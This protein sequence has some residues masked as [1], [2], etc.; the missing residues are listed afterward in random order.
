MSVEAH[1]IQHRA[2]L[3]RHHI[4]RAEVVFQQI[5]VFVRKIP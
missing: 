3:V 4:D 5:A 1:A 2:G